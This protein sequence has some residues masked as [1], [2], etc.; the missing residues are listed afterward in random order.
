M[1][2]V[3]TCIICDGWGLNE[4]HSYQE[5]AGITQLRVAP[6]EK[7]R[8]S[9]RGTVLRQ[10]QEI[11]VARAVR[12]R[13][14]ILD[15]IPGTAGCHVQVQN[16][17]DLLG[18]VT[19]H[20]STNRA[21]CGA[22]GGVRKRTLYMGS[23]LPP[24]RDHSNQ[25]ARYAFVIVCLG[26]RQLHRNGHDRPQRPHP[27]AT[28]SVRRSSNEATYPATRRLSMSQR[29]EDSSVIGGYTGL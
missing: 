11:L 17:R 9:T 16:V 14:E 27:A 22:G 24:Q 7:R 2:G 4:Q 20:S 6:D 12:P 25:L 26:H 29:G 3:W 19:S 21:K 10:R 28:P 13:A 5:A 18:A 23:E 1:S 8:S 15:R